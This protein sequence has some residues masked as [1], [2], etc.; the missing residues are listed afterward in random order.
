MK[1]LSAIAA[2]LIAFLGT[3]A[4]AAE[5][6]LYSVTG[7]SV[8]A[9]SN[10]ANAARDIALSQGRPT[11]WQRLYRRLTPPAQWPNQ[12]NPDEATLQ[13]MILSMEIANERR[14]TTR[15]LA[16][17][18]YNFNPAEVQQLLR[19]NSVPFADTRARPVL[20]IPIM[21]GVFDP[22]SEWARA[23]AQPSIANG[24]VPV[25]LPQGDARDQPLL[26]QPGLGGLGWEELAPLAERYDV[27]GVV[28]AT[29]TPDGNAAQLSIVGP[30]G[31]Q[32]DSL[33]FAQSSFGATADAAAQRIAE[34]WKERAAVDYSRR[35]NLTA[36]VIF[37]RPGDWPQIRQHLADVGTVAGVNVLGISTNEARIELSYFGAPDQLSDAMAQQNLNFGQ[38]QGGYLLR[39]GAPGPN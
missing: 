20:V 39:L 25:V 30:Q 4:M 7:V 2:L 18:T 36:D 24:L 35:A 9:T 14:S 27:G 23:W 8:D 22:N 12:P 5:S 38:A 26:G 6:G 31:R 16:D 13:R 28:V 3:P 33:A 10:S 17:V 1:R 15:Y 21:N 34:D 37:A 19:R 32:V 29:A 11:A